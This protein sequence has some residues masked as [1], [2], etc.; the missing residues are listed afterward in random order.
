MK[1]ERKNKFYYVADLKVWEW[2]PTINE[3]K[4]SYKEFTKEFTDKELKDYLEIEKL[5]ILG[6]TVIGMICGCIGFF[7]GGVI[8]GLIS[9][10]IS[11]TLF[12]GLSL[13]FYWIN[14]CKNDLELHLGEQDGFM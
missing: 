14:N 11:G 8:P 13:L 7:L 12:T 9:M 5:A 1:K 2:D 3:I 4:E 6:F 10:L